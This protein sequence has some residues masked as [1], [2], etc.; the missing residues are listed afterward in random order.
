[1][2]ATQTTPNYGLPIYGDTDKTSWADFNTAMTTIDTDLKGVADAASD[3][4]GKLPEMQANIQSLTNTVAKNT[5][6]IGTNTSAIAQ[7]N[8]EITTSQEAISSLDARVDV[9]EGNISTLQ[10]QVSETV[11]EELQ[12]VKTDVTTVEGNV[13]TLSSTVSSLGTRTTNLEAKVNAIPDGIGGTVEGLQTEVAGGFVVNIKNPINALQ[14]NTIAAKRFGIKTDSEVAPGLY[15]FVTTLGISGAVT[16]NVMLRRVPGASNQAVILGSAFT[17]STGSIAIAGLALQPLAANF[18]IG[19]QL[20][21]SAGNFVTPASSN[22]TAEI[23]PI[24]A[25]N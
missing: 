4:S 12:G 2:A 13:S 25:Y 5:T 17:E 19:F 15:Y 1:M 16:G 20:V 14:N 24:K 9:A 23:Y 10:T 8:V 11:L 18:T 3:T 22:D 6:D 21:D 7:A